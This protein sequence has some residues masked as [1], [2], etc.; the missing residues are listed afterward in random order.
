M[1]GVAGQKGWRWILIIEGLPS[2]IL[3]LAT[4]FLL[5]DDPE[6]ARYLSTEEKNLIQLRRQRQAELTASAREFHKADVYAALKD[7][8]VY[9]FAAGQFG[10]DTMLYGY[11]TFLPTI[12]KGIDNNLFWDEWKCERKGFRLTKHM[13]V[14][15]TPSTQ[16]GV[17]LIFRRAKRTASNIMVGNLGRLTL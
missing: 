14:G 11:S 17:H 10:T 7:W 2:V 6:T 15:P 8:K 9:A 12:I 16:F 4:W 3:G 13:I 1:D 5:A